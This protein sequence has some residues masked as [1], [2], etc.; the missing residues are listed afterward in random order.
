MGLASGLAQAV[1]QPSKEG[2]G[3]RGI[4]TGGVN[5]EQTEKTGRARKVSRG[6]YG[7]VFFVDEKQKTES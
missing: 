1:D 5:G 4:A 2:G 6:E 3:V 7:E